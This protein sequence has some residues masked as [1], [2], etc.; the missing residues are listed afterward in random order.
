LN[1]D[2]RE[3]DKDITVVADLPGVKKEDVFV[4]SHLPHNML[5]ISVRALVLSS[6]DHELRQV[7][8]QL[9]CRCSGASL[10]GELHG[11]ALRISCLPKRLAPAG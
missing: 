6:S 9:G 4:R 8:L 1:V 11:E 7:P 10:P 3:S 2:V 5:E